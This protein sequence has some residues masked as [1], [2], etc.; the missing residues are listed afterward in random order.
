[1]STPGRIEVICR[2]M[3]AGKTEGLLRRVRRA[4][5]ADRRVASWPRR[6]TRAIG[7]GRLASLAQAIP[8][9]GGR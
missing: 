3:F 6:S 1:M 8:W 5:I 2:P 7:G 9:S 4:V